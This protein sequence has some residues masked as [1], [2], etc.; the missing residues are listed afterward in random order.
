MD[1]QQANLAVT[2]RQ[3]IGGAAALAVG[4]AVPAWAQAPDAWPNVT[5]LIA[6]YVD[7]RKVAN[8]VVTLGFG[9]SPPTVIAGGLDSFTGLRRSDI[10][11]LYRLYSM[12]KPVTGMAAMMLID[13]GKLGLDQPLHEILPKF[14]NMQVQKV[15][16]GPITPDNL[17]P[18]VR[19]IT[20]RQMLTHTA[21][22]GYG[23]VQSGPI[24]QA[25]RDRGVVPGL[26][27][28]LQVLPVFRGT[29]VRG[30]E[31]FA[32]RLA[33]FPLVY[34][35]GT[36]WSYSMAF[37]LMGRVIEVVSGQPFDRFLQERFLDPLGM[38]DT[39]FQVPRPKA[40]RMTTT[41]LLAGSTLVP[42]DLGTDSIYFDDPPF[43]FGGA[44]LAGT[45]RDYDKFLA[46]LLNYGAFEGKRI[47]SERAVRLGISNLLPDTLAPGGAYELGAWDFGAGGRVGKG[48]NAGAYGWAGAAGTI[49]FV[50][51]PLGLRAGLYTQ[52]MPQMAYPLIDEF[53]AA[54]LADLGRA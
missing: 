7:G 5:R 8:M 47:M 15:Y 25:F 6:R 51:H 31:A 53:P 43:P 52:Y 9:E 37:D 11:S 42:I 38:T 41:Y 33:E 23:I 48:A 36:K 14:A 13:E 45:P 26:V 20:I 19:P 54:I 29:A 34:Q 18:A 1:M 17:E 12:T 4:A 22:L 40:E 16:D 35:P 2:R 27:T 10:D 3:W 30:L 49:G 46:M 32:D 21:G 50:H 39:H 24:S 44:G 28:R